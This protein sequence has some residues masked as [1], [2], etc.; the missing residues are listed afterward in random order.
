MSRFRIWPWI[1]AGAAFAGLADGAVSAATLKTLYNFCALPHC[2]D[3]RIP[4]T[5]V[6]TDSGG[7]LYATTAAGGAGNGTVFRLAPDGKLTVLHV[8]AAQASADGAP[9]D[10]PLIMAPDGH[11]Y[12]AMRLGG[13]TPFL[14][15]AG[16]IFELSPENLTEKVLYNFCSEPNCAGGYGQHGVIRVKGGDLYG[17]TKAAEPDLTN[18]RRRRE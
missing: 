2:A 5:G 13:D 16:G 9:P 6:I 14:A 10:A 8:F 17:T 12:G 3:G 4:Q 7:N 11:L 15:D 18:R 1:A